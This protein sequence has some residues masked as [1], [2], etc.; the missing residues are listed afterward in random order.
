MKD[1][2]YKYFNCNNKEELYLKLKQNSIDTYK[3]GKYLKFNQEKENKKIVIRGQYKLF[4]YLKNNIP[5]RDEVQIIMFNSNME[6]LSDNKF[7]I[8]TQF[9]DILDKSYVETANHVILLSHENEYNKLLRLEMDFKLFGYK[10]I[11]RIE[12]DKNLELDSKNGIGNCQFTEEDIINGKNKN[13]KEEK[14]KI[15]SKELHEFMDYYAKNELLHLNIKDDRRKIK[16]IL[17]IA[18]QEKS[19]EYFGLITYNKDQNITNI[20]TSLFKG[21]IREAKIDPII[22]T[23]FLLN[24]ETD[25]LIIF[26]N[27]PSGSIS[28]SEGDIHVTEVIE[29]MAM[30]FSK[31][32]EDHFIIG[33]NETFSFREEFLLSNYSYERSSNKEISVSE[34]EN[35]L[36]EDI[37]N[38]TKG[39]L[40][41]RTTRSRAR[42]KENSR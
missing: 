13:F 28:P 1:S 29:K 17:K 23:P 37:K 18:N 21:G 22:I 25:G 10:I 40:K 16:E 30:R 20:E 35:K 15:N 36:I 5:D 4:D 6:V 7:P 42:T 3:L 24:Q 11:D 32:V 31:S 14:K 33:K 39:K 27:H 26:H 38:K 41:E 19:Q 12:L 34:K 8:N 2:F 9:K